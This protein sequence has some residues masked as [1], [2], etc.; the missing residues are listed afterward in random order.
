MTQIEALAS[1]QEIADAKRPEEV[2][3]SLDGTDRTGLV[4]TNPATM[5]ANLA[6]ECSAIHR[7]HLF[8]QLE[9]TPE[10]I[11]KLWYLQNTAV[12]KIRCGTYGK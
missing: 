1:L 9:P 7:A 11:R 12:K 4:G 6:I 2:F 5:L 10:I 3:G 8:D